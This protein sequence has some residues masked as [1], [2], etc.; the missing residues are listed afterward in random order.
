[1]ADHPITT[2]PELRAVIGSP[3]GLA[4]SKSRPTLDRHSRAFI[5]RS[6]FLCIATA[7]A[8]G[9]ADVSPRGDPPGFVQ[10]LDDRHVLIP[11]RPGNNR[12]D[13]MANILENPHVGLIFMIPGFDDTL[14][15]NGRAW[16]E[17]DPERLAA[18]SVEG[19]TPR[20]AIGVEVDEVFLHCA[21]AFRR[22][23]LWDPASRQDRSAMPGIARIIMEQVACDVPVDED[24]ARRADAAVEENYRKE[25]Y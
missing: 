22:S 1:M 24:E 10:I 19:R 3:S 8:D 17:H 16:I 11:E 14:R 15:L 23:R 4:V 18:M 12:A 2:E 21:K 25:L 9:R 20:L 6:P 7:A 5:E 13:T